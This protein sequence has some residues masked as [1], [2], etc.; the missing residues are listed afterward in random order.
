MTV[1]HKMLIREAIHIA[2]MYVILMSTVGYI[3]ARR[4]EKKEVSVCVQ[5][6]CDTFVHS[7]HRIPTTADCCTLVPYHVFAKGRCAYRPW[8]LTKR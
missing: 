7:Q 2:Y 8:K 3:S 4:S 5:I 1:V 6:S